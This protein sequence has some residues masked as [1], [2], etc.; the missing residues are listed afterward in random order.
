METKD[1]ILE[2]RTKKGLS[3]DELAQELY[4]TRQAVSRWETGE[5]IPNTEALK[6]L[7]KFFDVSINTLLGSPRQLICQ[8]CGMPL[9]D[10]VISKEADGIFNEEYCKWCYADGE[11]TYDNM[12]DL[13]E[14]CAQHMANDNFSSEQVRTYMQDMLPQ[15]NYWKRYAQLGGEDNFN[16]FKV[17][18][19]DEFNALHIEGMPKVESLNALV[20]NFVNL[21]FRLPNGQ[22]AKF[23]D[24]QATYLGN[25]LECEFSGNRCFGIV[26]NMEFLLVC[27]Y[28]ENGTNPE[29]V[30]YKKR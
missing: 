28:E 20:G 24:D 30:I 11:Y 2:L 15:L 12:D 17:Q 1:I 16:K 26:A 5:T 23:L 4:V 27:T 6:L 21:E 22:T 18:I 14:Y 3:Q 10:S 7:S 25:Q 13:I 9:E 8:C 19:I 29:L